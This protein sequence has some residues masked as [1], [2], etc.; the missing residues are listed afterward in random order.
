MYVQS[1][2]LHGHTTSLEDSPDTTD[3]LPGTLRCYCLT[4][5]EWGL[6]VSGTQNWGGGGGVQKK[7]FGILK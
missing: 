1:G 2:E 7:L 6:V 3:S 5:C 4:V